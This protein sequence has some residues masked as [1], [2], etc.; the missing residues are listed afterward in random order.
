MRFLILKKTHTICFHPFWPYSNSGYHT[1]KKKCFCFF[2]ILCVHVR[3]LRYCKWV[4]RSFIYART[5][6]QRNRVV[7]C[8]SFSSQKQ[9]LIAADLRW[10]WC[11]I[12]SH[13]QHTY[14]RICVRA[15]KKMQFLVFKH[16]CWL[17]SDLFPSKHW[18]GS[19]LRFAIFC[20]VLC[21]PA[22]Y[23]PCVLCMAHVSM[24]SAC[25]RRARTHHT[26]ALHNDLLLYY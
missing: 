18:G 4:H 24:G 11:Y 21:V 7:V 6:E 13:T 25:S 17:G 19:I 15:S 10:R 8:F 1:G 2:I 22:C 12:A 3:V 26:L 14:I 5:C 20:G 23:V 16:I 9:K